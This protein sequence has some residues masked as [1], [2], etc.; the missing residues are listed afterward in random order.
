MNKKN[1]LIIKI[2]GAIFVLYGIIAFFPN[3]QF[4]WWALKYP[5]AGN[6]IVLENLFY[7]IH[8]L[9][10]NFIIP[11]AAIICGVG[12]LR[13]KNW[14]QTASLLV[15][16]VLFILSLAGIINFIIMSYRL[17]DISMP[18]GTL[19]T[20]HSMI[21]TFLECILSLLIFIVLIKMGNVFKTESGGQKSGE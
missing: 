20:S 6:T 2:I 17:K 11:L 18:E 9:L 21:P 12:L 5:F 13:R 19:V 15:S 8:A 10:I 3:L 7:S 14:S 1:D 4:S 16:F